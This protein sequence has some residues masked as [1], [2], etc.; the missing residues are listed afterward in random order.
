MTSENNDD[1]KET[2][3]H[4]QHSGDEFWGHDLYPERRGTKSRNFMSTLFM[5]EGR[6]I[7]DKSRCEKMVY[8]CAMKHPLVK[9]MM[10]ALKSSGC[11]VDLRRNFSCET[12]DS[13]VTGGYDTEL[14]QIVICQ[15][16]I[17]RESTAASVLVH[18]MIHM[19]DFCRHK[20]DFKNI[21]H[22]ACTEIRA[23]NLTYCSFAS[24]VVDG[25]AS[26]WDV[27]NRHQDC[28]K[29]RAML[30]VLAAR[31]VTVAE[32]AEAVNRVFN[33]CYKDL[34]PIGRRIY[35]PREHMDQ[36][37]LDASYFYTDK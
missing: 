32:A 31:A 28:V 36:A 10:M 26:F 6:E 8:D 2:P 14:N 30:S 16:N 4:S 24:A 25:D 20:M 37:L 21:D 29:R 9:L 34:E 23:A 1:H 22:L 17:R 7:Y 35:R 33:K 27:K 18:E 3:N 15:N 19:F 13:L 11:P 5:K 12:C